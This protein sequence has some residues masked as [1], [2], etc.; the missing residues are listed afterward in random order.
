MNN[1]LA[2]ILVCVA[3]V[4]STTP[5][6]AAQAQVTVPMQTERSSFSALTPLD[7]TFTSMF[8]QQTVG[9]QELSDSELAKVQGEWLFVVVLA[10]EFVIGVVC[11]FFC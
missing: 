10:A 9:F 8:T 5:I 4:L 7:L 3:L 1:L 11:W 2:R 6:V